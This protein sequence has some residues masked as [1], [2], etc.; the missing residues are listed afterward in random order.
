MMDE[1]KKIVRVPGKLGSAAPHS[2]L[3]IL[4]ATTGQ[5]AHSQVEVFEEMVKV[6]GL[7]VTKL[8]GSSKA[9]VLVS[10][11]GRFGLPVHASGVGE[12]IGDLSPF[13]PA[14]FANSLLDIDC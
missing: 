1:L 8:D 6:T 14:D 2:V 9:G 11:A 10:L 5:N 12:Q 4:D 7:I 3:L 13:E